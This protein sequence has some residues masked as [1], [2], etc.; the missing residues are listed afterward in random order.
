M[1][2]ATLITL[3]LTA[4]TAVAAEQAASAVKPTFPAL[5]AAVDKDDVAAAEQVVKANPKLLTARNAAEGETALHRCR[6]VAMAKLLLE[7]GAEIDARDRKANARPVRWAASQWRPEV[8]AFLEEKG[9]PDPDPFYMAATGKA[10]ELTQAL[11]QKPERLDARSEANDIFGG[12]RH[13]IHVAATYGQTACAK[14]L[15]DAG[16][17]VNEPGGWCDSQPLENAAWAG[18]T[19]TVALLIENGADLE[20]RATTDH[21]ALWY[22]AITGRKEIVEAMLK[23]GAKPE[24]GLVAAVRDAMRAPYFGRALPKREDYEAVIQ[25]LQQRGA[26]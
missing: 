7:Q 23:A 6:S 25:A 4:M 19:D 24:A 13:L 14:V 22:A 11:I 10:T 5:I 8:V 12:S 18:F 9:G 3:I 26:Q 1:R 17:N 2:I 20:A 16:A 21:T 15:L